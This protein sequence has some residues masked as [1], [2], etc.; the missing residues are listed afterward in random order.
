M[1]GNSSNNLSKDVRQ[2]PEDITEEVTD[3]TGALSDYDP[4]KEFDVM[5]RTVAARL[6]REKQAAYDDYGSYTGL[7]AT[8]RNR[9]RDLRVQDANTAASLN[10]AEGAQAAN[11]ANTDFILQRANLLA[12]RRRSGFTSGINTKPGSDWKSAAIGA[13]ASI[14]IAA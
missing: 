10:I 1:R 3:T 13:G 8:T 9:L 12:K 7:D 14:A 11:A 5:N 6:S 2:L 4:R